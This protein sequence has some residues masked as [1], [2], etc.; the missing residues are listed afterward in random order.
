MRHLIRL[1]D[2][3]K[4]EAAE[5]FKI[6]DGIK[7]GKY[8]DYLKGKT[9]VM[10]FP[11]SSIRTRVTFE[12]GI[13]LLGGQSLLFSPETLDKKEEIRDVVGYLN[14]WADGLIVRH[15]NIHLLEQMAYCAEMPII[16]AMTSV[17]HPCEIMADLY[18]LSKRRKDL[19]ADR[20]L[21]VGAAAN[22]GFAWKEASEL[23]GFSLEQCCPKGYEMEGVRV[24]HDLDEAVVDKDIVCTDPVGADE[25]EDFRPFRI[26]L[27][28]MKKANEG[29]VLNPCPP[30]SRG[31]EVDAEVME[32][33]YF[34]GYEFKKDLLSIQQA[35]I[36]FLSEQS[37]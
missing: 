6:A 37:K 17:N 13:Y 19:C 28:R 21:F 18:A 3:S 25:M 9:I 32:S 22:I 7:A 10:F 27:E 34:V 30:F 33:P 15:K 8:E 11:A 29:A 31:E 36:V 12:K 4:E 14:N 16:N 23:M 2:F 1:S 26:T 35:I 20:Y 24:S 5:I